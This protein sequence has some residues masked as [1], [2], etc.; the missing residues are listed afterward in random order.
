M[1]ELA[2]LVADFATCMKRIDSRRPVAVNAR[3]GEAYQP[4]IGPHSE[5]K[6]VDL[7]AAELQGLAPERYR[8]RVWTDVPYPGL[9][10]QKCDL[11]I[12]ADPDW[13]WVVEAKMLRLMGDNGKPNDNMLMHILS[14]YAHDRSA[15]TD[16]SK[17]VDSGFQGRKAIVIFGYD[18]PGLLMDPAIDAFEALA[19]KRVRIGARI[20]GSYE[21]LVHPVHRFGRVFGW[22]IGRG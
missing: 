9:S 7:V 6:T 4:G 2:D 19:E 15:L 10:R 11:C 13:E 16:C 18:F 17:L 14:P 5:T 21:D 20:V 8:G 12:G 22:A 1:I 3:T